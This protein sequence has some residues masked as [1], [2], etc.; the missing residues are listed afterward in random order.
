[1][2]GV[3]CVG[4]NVH[5]AMAVHAALAVHVA[6]VVGAALALGYGVVGGSCCYAYV[7]GWLVVVAVCVCVCVLCR[8][9]CLLLGVGLWAGGGAVG[10]CL[11]CMRWLLR[12]AVV[13]CSAL[14]WCTLCCA[15]L[16][17]LG[18]RCSTLPCSTLCRSTALLSSSPA[19]TAPLRIGVLCQALDRPAPL[20]GPLLFALCYVMRCSAVCCPVL[21]HATLLH[22][23]A[24]R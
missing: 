4:L 7:P 11:G 20:L 23:V 12:C 22:S 14:H 6:R 19:C 24:H 3:W 5:G 2:P 21:P 16:L 10:A 18:L 13:F 15:A 1:M 8:L 17:S 9:R